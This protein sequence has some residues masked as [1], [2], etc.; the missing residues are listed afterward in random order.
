MNETEWL[1]SSDPSA[2]LNRLLHHVTLPFAERGIPKPSERKLR[3]FACAVARRHVAQ[4]DR[5]LASRSID[6]V[7]RAVELDQR[8][9][10]REN[11]RPTRRCALGSYRDRPRRL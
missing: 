1:S 2:M 6:V 8:K 5:E 4:H 3:L 7:E 11:A 10:V 9:P